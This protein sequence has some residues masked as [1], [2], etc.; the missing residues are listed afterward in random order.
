MKTITES[1][2]L[3]RY[4]FKATD[5]EY[6]NLF[7]RSH[8]G[9]LLDRAL[10]NIGKSLDQ[11]DEVSQSEWSEAVKAASYQ[12]DRRGGECLI[13][14]MVEELPLADI[15]LHMKGII[16]WM[17]EL[18]IYTLYSCD[19]HGS[20]TPYVSLINFPTQKQTKLIEACLPEGVA[21]RVQGK[22]I[23]F[24][25]EQ[26]CDPLLLLAERLYELVV[27]PTTLICFQ[28][29]QF[30]KQSL[31]QLLNVLGESGNEEP[32][33][34]VVKRK[35][36]AFANDLFIDRAGNVCATIYCGE[37]P[38]VLLSAHMDIYQELEEDRQVIQEGTLLSSTKGILGADDRAGIAIILEVARN[39]HQTNFN[40]T[41]KIAFTVEEEVGLVGARKLDPHFLAD[42]D[43][44]VVVDRRGTRDIVTSCAG[45]IPYCPKSYGLLF[46][47]A[48][49]L[50]NMPDWK[51][52]KGGSSDT[53]I[54][55]QTFGIPSVNLSAGY[56]H[57]HS[58]QETLDYLAAYQTVKLIETLL[59]HQLIEMRTQKRI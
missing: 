3:I 39:I 47:K 53:K 25:C 52:T 32:I 27:D 50:S 17:N 15:D 46:E 14:P 54:L 18:E 23:L 35:L 41:L 1:Q 43:G 34:R 21:I 40:G 31:M 22:K 56:Q 30:Y 38:I 12:V 6:H 8:A 42:V 57:E 37:G 51:M 48:G 36:R 2:L 24:E 49:A 11:L 26:K 58:D 19:G 10:M 44:A 33:R 29:E 16:R 9:K 55:S 13:N 20:R 4:G 7:E 59:H 45:V 28:A 5:L